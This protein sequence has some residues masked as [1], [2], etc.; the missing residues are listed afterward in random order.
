MILNKPS[1][2][3][4]F[5]LMMNRLS[6][7][8]HQVYSGICVLVDDRVDVQVVRTDV[9]FRELTRE[10]RLHYWQTREPKDKA[11]GYGIQGLAARFVQSIQG[12]YTNVVGLPLVELEAMLNN[13]S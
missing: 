7:R 12:S 5:L 10:E 6:G 13:A 4:D 9:T 11:G 3:D 8:T 2:L 1:D